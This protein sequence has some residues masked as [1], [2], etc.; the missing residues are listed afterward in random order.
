[1]GLSLKEENDGM[2]GQDWEM[3]ESDLREGI[4]KI[5]GESNFE[6]VK[7]ANENDREMKSRKWR[8]KE[9]SDRERKS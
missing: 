5:S 8:S 7:D 9:Q 4:W 6:K 1:M 3:E 2:I